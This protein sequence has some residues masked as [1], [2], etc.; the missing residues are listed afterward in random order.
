MLLAVTFLAE[1]CVS[2]CLPPPITRAKKQMTALSQLGLVVGVE[3]YRF[4]AY[5]DQLVP[6]LQR[7]GMFRE[8]DHLR[9]LSSVDLVVRVEDRIGH[10]NPIPWIPFITL[11]IVPLIVQDQYGVSFSFS[12][13]GGRQKK[14]RVEYRYQT[15]SIM[16]WVAV[17]LNLL[18]A[19]TAREV[20][21]STRF[22]DHLSFIIA[23]R[24]H[25]IK[26][27]ADGSKR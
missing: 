7:T 25:A 8:V 10:A 17:P 24:V 16:G 19:W 20:E 14:V 6:V 23:E 11:G 13:M 12:A 18:P 3:E 1:G 15:T 21:S 9:N 27:L 5:S 26:A 22:L 4:P 2:T